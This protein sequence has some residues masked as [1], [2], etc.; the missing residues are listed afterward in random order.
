M[1]RQH[2]NNAPFSSYKMQNRGGDI[3]KS[4]I[5]LSMTQIVATTSK[6][7]NSSKVLYEQKYMKQK[8]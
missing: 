1:R 4:I 2:G 8:P 7:Y 3:Q 5:L 6:N